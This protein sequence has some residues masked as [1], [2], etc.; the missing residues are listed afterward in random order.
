MLHSLKQINAGGWRLWL[1]LLL[2]NV[3]SGGATTVLSALG[4]SGAKTIG[5]K[6]AELDFNSIVV[7]FVSGAIVNFFS[8]IKQSPLPDIKN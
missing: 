2:A 4:L 5:Y 7:L 3:I 6:V 1:K 8:Y